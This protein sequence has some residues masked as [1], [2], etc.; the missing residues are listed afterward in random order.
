[1]EVGSV[2]IIAGTGLI[3]HVDLWATID[4]QLHEHTPELGLGLQELVIQRTP[5]LTGALQADIQYEAYESPG[6]YGMEGSDLVY[7]YAAN[8]EQLLAWARIYAPYQ[9]GG[10]LGLPTYTN[11]PREMF[12]LT[13]KTDGLALVETWGNYY[14]NVA[15]GMCAM[16]VGVPF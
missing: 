7:V 16:G 13:A 10:P 5:F 12:Y 4:E 3:I 15:L 11:D 1:V 9:E 8:M 2:E 6:G 14:V